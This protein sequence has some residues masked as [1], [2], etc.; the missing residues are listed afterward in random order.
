LVYMPAA[1]IHASTTMPMTITRQPH[2]LVTCAAA[3]LQSVQLHSS[4]LHACSPMP[5]SWPAPVASFQQQPSPP[6]HKGAWVVQAAKHGGDAL[7]GRG[8]LNMVGPSC[9]TL[10][11]CRALSST[12]GP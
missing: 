12:E 3:P 11:Q 5:A 2:T 8:Q 4:T 10:K 1:C 6:K 9:S 7:G